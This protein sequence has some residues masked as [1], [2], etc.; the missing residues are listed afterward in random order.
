VVAVEAA[1][2]LRRRLERLERIR[3]RPPQSLHGFVDRI[4]ALPVD[5]SVDE[6]ER[7]SQEEV[8]GSPAFREALGR[9]REE[10]ARL[11]GAG[12]LPRWRES[13]RHPALDRLLEDLLTLGLRDL[14][15]AEGRSP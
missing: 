3:P 7:R 6:V 8:G 1:M 2:K 13:H 14:E 5:R 12:E 10:I 4:E 15:E 11:R 9:C